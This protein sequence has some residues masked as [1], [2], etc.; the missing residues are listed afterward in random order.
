M[1]SNHPGIFT[2]VVTGGIASGKTE[3]S[4]HFGRLGVPVIDTDRIA[5]ELVEPGQPALKRIVKTFGS[6]ILGPDSRLD[7]PRLRRLIFSNPR[8]KSRLEKILH[9]LIAVEAN[10]QIAALEAPYCIVVIPLYA[11]S[12]SY[13]WVDRVLVVD[14]AEEVQIERVMK[15]DSIGLRQAEAI[16]QAQADREQRLSLADDVLDN[17]GSLAHLQEQVEILH[18]RYLDLAGSA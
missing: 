9:P 18:R 5:R 16:L 3:V 7:R 15:R 11:E 17:N 13:S 8:L 1:Q 10:R 2:V 14:T 4:N 12:S 6:K